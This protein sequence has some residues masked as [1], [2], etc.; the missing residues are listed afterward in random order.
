[1]KTQHY[2]CQVVRAATNRTLSSP[3]APLSPACQQQHTQTHTQNVNK[4]LWQD[5]KRV[6]GCGRGQGGGGRGPAEAVY[7]SSEE[8]SLTLPTP[9]RLLPRPTQGAEGEG[10][11]ERPLQLQDFSQGRRG[12]GLKALLMVDRWKTAAAVSSLLT[13]PLFK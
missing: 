1:M 7:I 4:E 6:C 3:P 13:E 12:D 2:R 5:K 8:S 10:S 11:F 9:L